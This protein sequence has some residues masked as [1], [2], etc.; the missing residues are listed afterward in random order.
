[1]STITL[2]QARQI[3]IDLENT[4]KALAF[5]EQALECRYNPANHATVQEYRNRIV[6]KAL[7]LLDDSA[8]TEAECCHSASMRRL[9][10]GDWTLKML[11]NRQL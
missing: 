5:T 10:T 6:V 11:F 9:S 4:E 3:L 1:M 8:A 7:S 2:D